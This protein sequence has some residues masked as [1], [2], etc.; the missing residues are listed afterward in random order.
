MARCKLCR[1]LRLDHAQ[2]AK[3]LRLHLGNSG[4]SPSPYFSIVDLIKRWPDAPNRREV[5]MI[6]DGIDRF[7]WSGPDDP[8]V[9]SAIEA[10]QRARIIVYSIYSRGMGQYGHSFWRI[11][12]G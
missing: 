8:Y 2:A 9:D 4:A 3:A 11:N 10:A 5:L 12:S 6:S 7:S 1:I